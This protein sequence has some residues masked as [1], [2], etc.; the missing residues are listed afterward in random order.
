MAIKAPADTDDDSL[1]QCHFCWLPASSAAL[2]PDAN[3]GI[4]VRI[5]IAASA[6]FFFSANITVVRPPPRGASRAPPHLA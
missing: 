3:L 2:L 4:A 6:Y 1:A 5:A